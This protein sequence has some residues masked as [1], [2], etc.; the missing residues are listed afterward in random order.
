MAAELPSVVLLFIDHTDK[1]ILI[2]LKNI[3][4]LTLLASITDKEKKLT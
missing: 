3:Y 4:E 1:S 2:L